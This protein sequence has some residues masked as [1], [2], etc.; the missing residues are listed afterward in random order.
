MTHEAGDL[1]LC[2]AF[3]CPLMSLSNFIC[4]KNKSFQIDKEYNNF[5]LQKPSHFIWNNEKKNLYKSILNERQTRL[6]CD[7]I[8]DQIT[9]NG[10]SVSSIDDAVTSVTDVLHHAATIC[11]A[12]R[13]YRIK[14]KIGQAHKNKNWFDKDCETLKSE[15]LSAARNLQRYPKDPI[16]RGR[17]H[18]LKKEYKRLVKYKEHSFREAILNKI[19]DL[20]GNNPKAFWEMVNELKSNKDK[21]LADNIEPQEWYDWFKKL[22]KP[23]FTIIE[24][25]KVIHGIIER[26]RDFALPDSSLDKPV[27]NEE[28]IRASKHLKNGK[29]IG[30]DAISH[31]MIKCFVQTRFVDVVRDLFNAILTKSY[32]PKLWKIN[33]ISPIFKS[34]DAFDPNNY[35]GIAV[36]SCFDK[37]FTLVINE[38]LVE[39][40]DLRNNLSYF[41]IGFRSRYRTSDHVFILNTILNSYFHK[42]KRVYACFVDFSKAYDSVW[43]D[44]LLHK[45][46]LNGL[47]FKFVSLISYMYDDLQMT[48]K[49]SNGITPYFSSLMG[50]MQG[51]NLSP[52]LF[53]IF[54][55]DIFDFFLWE[56][57]LSC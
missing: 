31:E 20:E 52:L 34:D 13:K 32:F 24:S 50:V 17:Y 57:V 18:K 22:N 3:V 43:R 55:N 53:D 14:K 48:V 6:K 7:T 8:I 26:A 47:S 25:D 9:Q 42:G 39:Y 51:C 28:I 46:I 23:Q 10:F 35:R 30:N 15:V 37:L 2:F 19:G 45:L 4:L 54:V 5:L 40:L 11:F 12:L 21:N 29:A 44:G 1:F 33:Y 36:S 27:S 41:Q 16:V 56:R 49:L 38:R